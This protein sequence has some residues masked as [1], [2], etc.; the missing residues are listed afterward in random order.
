MSV[1]PAVDQTGQPYAYAAGN[2]V[3]NTDPL[4]LWALP[5][6]TGKVFATEAPFEAWVGRILGVPE[7][8]SSDQFEVRWKAD[9]PER[10]KELGARIVD[11][12]TG[13]PLNFINEVKTGFTSLTRGPRGTLS[14]SKRDGYLRT[15]Q[16]RTAFHPYKDAHGGKHRADI[17][18]NTANWW[19]SAKGETGCQAVNPSRCASGPLRA[20]LSSRGINRIY[21]YL[22]K[23]K[24]RK[25]F[26]KTYYSADE[27]AALRQALSEETCPYKYLT[28]HDVPHALFRNCSDDNLAPYN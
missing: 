15:S 24:E 23:R 3:S 4:G 10:I 12:W 9:T 7:L 27:K 11:I 28:N 26:N 19:F 1:D 25:L 17:H 8:I 16:G 18:V 22:I 5:I 13:N 21:V 20:D 14:E 2:P 6:L